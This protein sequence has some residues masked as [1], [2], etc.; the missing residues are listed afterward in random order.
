MKLFGT[1][2]LLIAIT[3]AVVAGTTGKI[4]GEVKDA[5]S[6][7]ALIGATI[8]VEGTTLGAA[9][10]VEGYYVIL[11][12]PPGKYNLSV[13]SL[14][15][16]KKTVSEVM[17]SVDLTTT[18]D[19]SLNQTV[20]EIGEEV[21][22]T[23]ERPLVRRDLTS[24]EARVNADEIKTLPVSEVA[25]VLSLQ[26]GITLGSD[27]AI[28]IRGG[29]T[30]EVAYWVD[31]ISVSDVYDGSQAVQ[32]DNNSI[33]ELQVI[34]GTFNAE[35][36]QAMSGIVNIVTKDGE[37]AYHGSLS[38]YTGD[39]ATSDGW[40]Y[41][42]RLIVVDGSESPDLTPGGIFYNLDDV[43][44]FDNYN[45]EG[46]LSGPFPGLGD[47]ATFYVSGRYFRTDGWLYGNSVFNPNGSI[48]FPLTPDVLVFDEDS[49]VVAVR[50]P[51]NP[52]RMNNRERKSGQAK[53]T[54]QLSGSAKLSLSG[55]ASKIEY[56][57][58]S[59]DRFL[60]PDGDVTKYDD[61]YNVSALWTHTLGPTSFYTLTL[62][63]FEKV[64]KEFLYANT[65]DSNYIVDPNFATVQSN[66]FRP[67]G[68][69]NH[70]FRR[71]T[72]TRAVKFDYTDQ[73]SKLHQLKFGVEAKLHQLYLEDYNLTFDEPL[74]QT[75]GI[76]VPVIPPRDGPLY[77]EYT[78]KPLEF[79]VYLQDKLEYE[80]M[81][82]NV[83]LRFDYFKSKGQI[84]S[85]AADPNVYLPR[86]IE[87]QFHDLNGNG[88]QD[89]GE[90]STTLEERLAYWYEDA[91]PKSNLSPRFGISYP[92][93]DQ[94]I[95]HFSYGHFL[96]IPSFIH[97]YQM[98][99]YKVTTASGI[100]GV[101]GNPDLEAQQTIMYE[102]GLQQQL[103]DDLSFDV[104]MFYR[105]TRDWVTT[106]SSIDV[107]DPG[108]S[109]SAY[110]MYVNRD[111]ANVRGVTLSVTKRPSSMWSLNFSYT[112][113]IAEG[114]NSNPDDELAA[115]RNN[116]E[117]ARTLT[118]LDWDQ[119]HTANLTL[120]FGESDWG[121]YVIGRYG[122]GLPYTPS[123]SQ[124][125]AQGQDVARIVTNNSRR[126]PEN[127]TVDLRVFK[128]FTVAPLN[129]SFFLKV[130]NLFDRRN[131]ISVYGETG[132]A[133]ATVDNL[134]L[135]GITGT[136][137]TNAPE[138]YLVRPDYYSE[139]R[140]IQLGV[141]V[142]F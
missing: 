99:E 40:G 70:R 105:D 3:T 12:I 137:R 120:G 139:P 10:N 112:F 78:R 18:I 4:V 64:F 119:T 73:I 92:I 58:Y 15:Y 84:L 108:S 45:V 87:N 67:G 89:A 29:R 126:R 76:Y 77:Q 26:S 32:V 123:I 103:T 93:T 25:E 27:G 21:V 94:G 1:V 61:G 51:D 100:Q 56:R 68:T 71:N 19:F 44:P 96:Q 60:S 132:R 79:S 80:R 11:N 130:F 7:E 142:N 140:E 55:L 117:P 75:T 138:S 125:E 90:A 97:L 116:E 115:Q 129:L 31:G 41:N 102:F 5:Q 8:V 47:A 69:N 2:I 83:G 86:K 91:K 28:H 74:F 13:T 133:S 39:Y 53:L 17:V 62:S 48:G 49:N 66:E 35:Y 36:G 88:L 82:V 111:Y 121:A 127:Y 23:A 113:Q 106:S 9:A 46:S 109:T 52:V 114:I 24:S 107:G 22:V 57:D 37:G 124:A 34:S 72:E 122:S 101:F 65:L 30:S 136:D 33:Q 38:A 141:E 98:P 95:L 110:T 128:N 118:P 134:G 42:N 63:F 85:D 43:N 135:G 14:G 59:H 20:L 6:G 50:L 104:T 16:T 81:I 131:E 54:Y